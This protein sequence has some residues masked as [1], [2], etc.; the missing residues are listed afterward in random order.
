MVAARRRRTPLQHIIGSVEFVGRDFASGPQAMVPR[1]ETESLYRTF[2]SLLPERPS[3][4]MDLGTG[5]GVLGVSLALRYPQALVVGVDISRDAAG[6]ARGNAVSLG[7]FGFRLVISDL[8]AAFTAPA[9]FDGIVANLPY[10]PSDVVP[11]LQPEVRN[12]D[13]LLALDGGPD[14]LDLV[15]RALEEA[16]ALLRPGGALALELGEDQC[17]EVAEMI[18]RYTGWEAVVHPDLSGRPRIVTSRK[19]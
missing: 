11:G 14:G 7:A 5:C 6:L 18:R 4:L 9:P 8:T 12:G 1:P 13:P 16:P 10:I 3:L 19:A 2:V 15:R 17:G